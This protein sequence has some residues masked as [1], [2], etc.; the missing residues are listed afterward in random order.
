MKEYSKAAKLF[1]EWFNNNEEFSDKDCD[2]FSRDFQTEILETSITLNYNNS[3]F[4]R[5]GFF[6]R[7]SLLVFFDEQNIL[8]D[9]V[10]LEKNKFFCTVHYKETYYTKEYS[11]R[12]ESLNE[13]FQEAFRLLEL[14]CKN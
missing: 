13:A 7:G 4:K 5:Y 10:A 1:L 12:F 3:F 14:K 9:T 8:I 11:T 6:N 2:L